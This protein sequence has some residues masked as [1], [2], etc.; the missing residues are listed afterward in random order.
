MQQ[1]EDYM[2]H[3]VPREDPIKIP[4]KAYWERSINEFGFSCSVRWFTNPKGIPIPR[5]EGFSDNL[6]LN[7][8]HSPE[9]RQYSGESDLGFRNTEPT[10]RIHF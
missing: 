9:C 5:T 4:I 3:P 10:A 1:Q 8:T 6:L 2:P 7:C